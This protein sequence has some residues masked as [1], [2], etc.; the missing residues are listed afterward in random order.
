S[1]SLSSISLYT[2]FSL[3]LS[4]SLFPSRQRPSTVLRVQTHRKGGA[5]ER[6]R[7]TA[8]TTTAYAEKLFYPFPSPDQPQSKQMASKEKNTSDPT[9]APPHL[10]DETSLQ[11]D[12]SLPPVERQE[13]EDDQDSPGRQEG[14]HPLTSRQASLS[15]FL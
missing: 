5:G 1:P 8:S 7:D 9:G 6:G 13:N 10:S 4:L 2:F 14:Q 15:P 12:S 3:S 11:A